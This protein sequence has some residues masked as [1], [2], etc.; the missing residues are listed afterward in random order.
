MSVLV[1]PYYADRNSHLEQQNTITSLH[2]QEVDEASQ[3]RAVLNRFEALQ[4]SVSLL[5]E[6]VADTLYEGLY[7]INLYNGVDK[8]I[9]K[10]DA[11]ISAIFLR[12][13][14]QFFLH[15]SVRS[16]ELFSS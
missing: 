3:A 6:L 11:L 9:L 1:F 8:I 15:I 5:V 10:W 13:A 4:T 2:K 16:L 7:D 12:L 14:Y